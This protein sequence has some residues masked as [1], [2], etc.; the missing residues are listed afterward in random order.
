M[1]L[2][3]T[4]CWLVAQPNRS[5]PD[6]PDLI[7]SLYLK[8]ISVQLLLFTVVT[9]VPYAIPVFVLRIVS[10]GIVRTQVLTVQQAVSININITR[11]TYIVLICVTLIS[12]TKFENQTFFKVYLRALRRIW[13]F[14]NLL[15]PKISLVYWMLYTNSYS[16]TLTGFDCITDLLGE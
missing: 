15:K 14:G 10:L 12:R 16:L 6:D 7:E 1:L 8:W 5:C 11:I 4:E 9:V 3:S 13:K 2:Y